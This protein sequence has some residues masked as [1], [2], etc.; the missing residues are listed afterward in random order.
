MADEMFRVGIDILKI[1]HLDWVKG[2][3][4]VRW[5]E[6]SLYQLMTVEEYLN[7]VCDFVQRLDP[8]IAID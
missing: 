7:P 3:A 8:K 2:T 5:H 1:H 4:L 6:K